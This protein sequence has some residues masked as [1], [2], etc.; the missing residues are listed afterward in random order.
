VSEYK[1]RKPT[2]AAPDFIEVSKLA[3]KDT[4]RATSPKPSLEFFLELK[5][6]LRLH[7]Y[8]NKN[9]SQLSELLS[10]LESL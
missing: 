2:A 9:I 10:A 1:K 5:N 7:F 3:P 6:G 4:S 8:L